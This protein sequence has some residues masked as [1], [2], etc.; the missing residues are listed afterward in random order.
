[1]PSLTTDAPMDVADVTGLVLAGGQG[2]RMDNADKG[3]V[4]FRGKPMVLHALERLAPHVCRLLISANRNAGV[5]AGF[6]CEVL[7]DLNDTFAG[8]LAGLQAALGRCET[9]W[10][11]MVPCDVPLFPSELVPVM[12]RAAVAADA[13][14]AV[15]CVQGERQAVFLL[16]KRCAAPDLDDYLQM[17]RRSVLGFIEY[18]CGKDRK[19]VEVPFSDADHAFANINTLAQLNELDAD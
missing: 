1:M 15:A 13:N 7:P 9:D 16:I 2:S 17:Q 3:L 11:M 6:G 12:T 14:V 4:L 10:L 18:L 8:P 19:L 5:Y